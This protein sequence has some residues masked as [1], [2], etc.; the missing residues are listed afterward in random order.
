[1]TLTFDAEDEKNTEWSVPPAPS[2][3]QRS[4]RPTPPALRTHTIFH[5]HI[6]D[7]LVDQVKS[8]WAESRLVAA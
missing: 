3:L 4:P 2:R 8:F 7:E 1:M 6:T 5:P